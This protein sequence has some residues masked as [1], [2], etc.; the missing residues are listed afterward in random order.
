MV[1]DDEPLSREAIS[2]AL[3]RANLK[4]T[5]F[6]DPLAAYETL[7]R[8]SCDLVISDVN[9]PGLDGFELCKRRRKL[10]NHTATP[11]IFVTASDSFER[12][13]R[14]AQSGGSDFIVKPVHFVELAVK[15]LIGAMQSRLSA[16]SPHFQ[17]FAGGA[18]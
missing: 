12:H 5:S 18:T 10:P 13:L 6:A 8:E 4:A 14:A 16:G 7:T 3:E 9:M 11:V 2:A 17:R 15:A 1:V